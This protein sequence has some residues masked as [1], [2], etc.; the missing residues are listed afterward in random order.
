MLSTILI[1]LL[2]AWSALGLMYFL[3][4]ACARVPRHDPKNLVHYLH[5]VDWDLLESLL[6]PAADFELR[7]RLSPREFREEQRC[8]MRLFRE[9]L[10]RMSHNSAVLAEFDNALFGKDDFTPGPGSKV[11]EAAI[12]VR[13]YCTAA[14]IK[15]RVW[16]SLPDTLRAVPMPDLARLRMAADLDGPKVYEELKAAAVEAFAD[17][18]PAEL[19]ALTRN[20]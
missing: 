14:R 8:R 1:W 3:Y 7:W 17:L 2:L 18:Q 15:L 10:R 19:D 16:L 6:D 20:L 13:L 9:L 12:K 5:P 11:E 4:R